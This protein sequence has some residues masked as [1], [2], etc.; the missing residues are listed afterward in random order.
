[1]STI[2]YID[3]GGKKASS[4]PIHK[5]LSRLQPGDTLQLKERNKQLELLSKGIP[6]AR[7]S[8]S[9]AKRWRSLLKSIKTAKIIAITVRHRDDSKD[10]A[11]IDRYLMESWELPIVELKIG[12]E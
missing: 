11:F 12:I 8:K 2:I 4:H 7:L 9:T 1:M 6:V 3:Y 10:N 5:E